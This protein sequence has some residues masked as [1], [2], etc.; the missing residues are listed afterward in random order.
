MFNLRSTGSTKDSGLTYI[1]TLMEAIKKDFALEFRINV[2][3]LTRRIWKKFVK[4]TSIL[5]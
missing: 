2:L 5:R 3:F 1:T 4:C